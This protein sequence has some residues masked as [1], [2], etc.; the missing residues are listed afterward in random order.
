[1]KLDA[2]L[3]S[4]KTTIGG[5]VIFLAVVFPQLATYW[6]GI[7]E[8]LPDW[9]MVAAAFGALAAAAFARDGDK[10]SEDHGL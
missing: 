4:W 6:D 1:M 7:P 9:N 8:T 2:M 3:T 5:L 10:K